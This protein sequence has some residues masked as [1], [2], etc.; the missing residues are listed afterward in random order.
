MEE[1]SR[2][3]GLPEA[4]TADNKEAREVTLGSEETREAVLR[5][6]PPAVRC[7]TK[8]A[9]GM[10]AEGAWWT[11]RER[12]W[13]VD[14]GEEVARSYLEVNKDVEGEKHEGRREAEGRG[15]RTREGTGEVVAVVREEAG[16]VVLLAGGQPAIA[17]D[18]T[19]GFH[20]P[21][22]ASQSPPVPLPMAR[23]LQDDNDASL[24]AFLAA[25]P[26][27]YQMCPFCRYAFTRREAS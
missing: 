15:A 20:A 12:S 6:E 17:L 24:P 9:L 16:K 18:A 14:L 26:A 25:D 7:P 3:G 1:D 8:D 4:A 13:G 10:R 5:V 23:G 21:P 2:R 22:S 11:E 27:H 19:L